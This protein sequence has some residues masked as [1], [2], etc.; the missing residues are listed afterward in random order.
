MR[1]FST[2]MLFFLSLLREIY[3]LFLKP[4]TAESKE[5]VHTHRHS[6]VGYCVMWYIG[7]LHITPHACDIPPLFFLFFF[8]SFDLI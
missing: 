4:K 6:T 3:L 2:E 8:V 7:S 1:P 5:E